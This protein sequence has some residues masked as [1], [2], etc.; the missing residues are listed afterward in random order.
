MDDDVSRSSTGGF[1]ALDV[2]HMTDLVTLLMPEV[3]TVR[4][5]G[6]DEALLS[7]AS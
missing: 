3:A 6:D 4:Y 7:G 5:F 2:S 1:I